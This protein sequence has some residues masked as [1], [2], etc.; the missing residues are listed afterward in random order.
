[1]TGPLKRDLRFADVVAL[2]ING[3]IGTGIFF[4]PGEAAALLGPAATL[5]FLLSAILSALLVLCFAE[6][7]SRFRTT[8]GPM[9]YAASAFGRFVGFEVGWMTLVVRIITWGALGNAMVTAMVAIAPNAAAYGT[10]ILC[11]LFAFIAAVNLS[12]VR[13]SARA[14][15]FFTLAKLIPMIAF[16]GVGIFFF[17]VELTRPF[18]P[19]GYSEIGGATLLLFFA[20]VGFEVTSVPAGEMRDPQRDV[21]RGLITTMTVITVVYLSIWAVCVGTLP[22]LAGS[23]SPVS[24]AANLFMGPTGALLV[25]SGILMSVIGVNFAISITAS[26]TLYALASDGFLPAVFGR[27]HASTGAP[28]PAILA[29][30]ALSLAVAL[31]GSYVELAVLSVLARFTQFIPTCIAVLVWRRRACEASAFRVPGG[32][33]VPVAALGICAWLLS[34]AEPRQIFWGGVAVAIGAALYVLGPKSGR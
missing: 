20:F 4:L 17:D 2:G 29:T 5:A 11:L 9:L 13:S 26:R 24:D 21:P 22:A 23:E 30:S 1:M 8:G 32:P 34:Q 16:V 18:A 3:V 27:T 19:H 14:T 33:I 28:A 12:G 10:W 15:N 6:A 25:S 7:G 31:S